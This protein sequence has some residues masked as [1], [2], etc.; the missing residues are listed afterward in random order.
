MR[1][2]DRIADELQRAHNG[3]AWH[4]PSV[5]SALEGVDRRMATTRPVARGHTICE[6]VLHLTAWT[7]EVTRRM[8]EGVARDP[9]MGDWPV[10]T[11]ADDREWSA[12]IAAFDEANAELADAI[13]ALDES[14]LDDRIGDERDRAVGGGVSRYVMLHGL[15]QHH[16]YHA[17]QISFL[18]KALGPTQER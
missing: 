7:R 11:P 4:G 9:E 10:R 2:I 5:N 12:I 17:G 1:E 13:A 14:R 8:R 16:A 3:D 6:L 15:A 18:K